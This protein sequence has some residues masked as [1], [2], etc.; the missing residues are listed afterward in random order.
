MT[1]AAILVNQL[2]QSGLTDNLH[3]LAEVYFFP[4]IICICSDTSLRGGKKQNILLNVNLGMKTEHAS[5][6]CS[7]KPI[8]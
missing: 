4:K 8:T 5:L 3:H 7:L 2:E 1:K 6:S